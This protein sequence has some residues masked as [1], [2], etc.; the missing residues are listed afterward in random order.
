MIEPPAGMNRPE[1]GLGGTAIDYRIRYYFAAE[2][3][4]NRPSVAALGLEAAEALGG[5]PPEQLACYQDF[6]E[7]HDRYVRALKPQR[8]RLERAD[9]EELN[10]RC[11]VLAL[12]DQFYRLAYSSHISIFDET[13][14]HR[15]PLDPLS[16][17]EQDWIDDLCRMSEAF[18]VAMRE[19]L[20]EPHHLNPSFEGSVDVGG[21]DG[22]II[23]GRTLIDIKATKNP[24]DDSKQNLYQLLG[25][26]LLDY[27][28]RFGLKKLGLYLARYG[29]SIGW[30]IE[31]FLEQIGAPHSLEQHREELRALL[32][33]G[34]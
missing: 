14:L 30:T 26:V 16:I 22:D 12:F 21:A 20:H 15:A 29:V 34:A 10:R 23:V 2:P 27:S 11:V 8:R 28:D 33:S 6:L 17:P 7:S 32:Q 1:L 24:T 19:R 13:W 4:T 9:E 25:Y 18:Y 3:R 5:L 31:E